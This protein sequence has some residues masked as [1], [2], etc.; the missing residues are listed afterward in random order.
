MKCI[1]VCTRCGARWEED[2]EYCLNC[3]PVLAKAERE[4]IVEAFTE[5]Q[6]RVEGTKWLGE[7]S[8]E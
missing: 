1:T 2:F 8:E 5:H 6:D 3:E 4:G 7:A